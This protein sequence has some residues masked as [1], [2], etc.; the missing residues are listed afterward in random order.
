MTINQRNILINL[1][2]YNSQKCTLLCYNL[3]AYTSQNSFIQ[4]AIRELTF[5]QYCFFQQYHVKGFSQNRQDSEIPSYSKIEK[6]NKISSIT[7]RGTCCFMCH[8]K[9]MIPQLYINFLECLIWDTDRKILFIVNN[10]K[11][12]HGKIV[13]ECLGKHNEFNKTSISTTCS[14]SNIILIL[15]LQFSSVRNFL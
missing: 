12:H 6:I 8:E 3:L 1:L 2:L 15:L 7:N 10:L 11:V 4:S 14:I 5:S 9:N 13:R